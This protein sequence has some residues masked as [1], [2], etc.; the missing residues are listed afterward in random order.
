[1]FRFLGNLGAHHKSPGGVCGET[2]SHDAVFRPRVPPAG[3]ELLVVGVDGVVDGFGVEGRVDVLQ[4]RNDVGV[5]IADAAN[6]K[7]VLVDVDDVKLVLPNAHFP[8]R[9]QLRA[10]PLEELQGGVEAAGGVLVCCQSSGHGP[11]SEAR[12]P[13]SET[14]SKLEIQTSQTC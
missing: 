4:E 9:A 8:Q 13:K 11:K 5:A 12:N 10:R 14:N 7:E 2:P 3:V 6:L 1:T